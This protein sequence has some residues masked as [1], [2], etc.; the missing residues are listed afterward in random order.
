RRNSKWEQ[1]RKRVP[2]KASRTNSAM[3][4]VQ[5]SSVTKEYQKVSLENW[6]EKHKL[7]LVR[8]ITMVVGRKRERNNGLPTYPYSLYHRNF[9]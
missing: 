1:L 3:V 5:P 9:C 2:T 6:L 8:R 7:L 4:A